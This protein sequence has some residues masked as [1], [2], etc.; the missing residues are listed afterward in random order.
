MSCIYTIQHT[1][2]AFIYHSVLKLFTGFASAALIAWKLTVNTAIAS[3]IAVVITKTCQPIFVRYAK[4]C[5]HLFIAN[6]ATGD[7]IRIAMATNFKNSFDNNETMLPTLA[8]NTFLTP[9]SLIRCSALKAA[10]PNS[11]RQEINIAMMVK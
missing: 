8:P 2:S 4:S 3:A 9:I 11:P 7:A 6:Q 1:S 5:N 10:R